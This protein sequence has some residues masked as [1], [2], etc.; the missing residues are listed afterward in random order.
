MINLLSFFV[1][2]QDLFF[3]DSSAI[4]YAIVGGIVATAF[5]ALFCLMILNFVK[6]HR[7]LRL[8]HDYEFKRLK[9]Q[10]CAFFAIPFIYYGVWTSVAILKQKF[11]SMEHKDDEDEEH[12]RQN[13]WSEDHTISMAFWLSYRDFQISSIILSIFIVCLKDDQDIL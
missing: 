10:L 9:G 5:L 4:G 11:G 7:S 2:Y 12:H 3:L 6:L 1:V 13:K 8:Y